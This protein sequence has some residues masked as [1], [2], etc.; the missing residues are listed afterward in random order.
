[1]YAASPEIAATEAAVAATVIVCT[2]VLG[3]QDNDKNNKDNS[4][5]TIER[6]EE[7]REATD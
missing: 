1:M 2:P 7:R 6:G 4:D 5:N 3:V